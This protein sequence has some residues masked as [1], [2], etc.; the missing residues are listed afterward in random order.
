MEKLL[1]SQFE[2]RFTT[3]DLLRVIKHQAPDFPKDQRPVLSDRVGNNKKGRIILQPLKKEKAKSPEDHQAAKSTL[4]R[5][6]KG[7]HEVDPVLEQFNRH[8]YTL[9]CAFPWKPSVEEI[10]TLTSPTM[11]HIQ[12]NRLSVKLQFGGVKHTATRRAV[13]GFRQNYKRRQSSSLATDSPDDLFPK[14][15]PTS[16]NALQVV[17]PSSPSASQASLNF[18][19][20]AEKPLLSPVTP[21]TEI[22]EFSEAV[23]SVEERDGLTPAG[24]KRKRIT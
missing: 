15:M 13:Q 18:K 22:S 7:P 23:E 8:V 24:K 10:T 12:R 5:E 19:D 14:R 17:T 21:N 16:M 1:E 9:H 3:N 20:F 6:G 11:N 2:G 4:T